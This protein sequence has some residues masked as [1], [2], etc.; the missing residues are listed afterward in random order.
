M[1]GAGLIYVSNKEIAP[2]TKTAPF[3]TVRLTVVKI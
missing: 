3:N 2:I 1:D